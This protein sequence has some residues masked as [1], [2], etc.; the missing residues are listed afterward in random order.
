MIC[1]ITISTFWRSRVLALR[2]LRDRSSLARRRSSDSGS[3]TRSIPPVRRSTSLCVGEITGQ[4]SSAT[5]EKA[6]QTIVERHEVLRTRIVEKDGEPMQEVATSY[7]FKLTV[8]DL[9][10]FPEANRLDEA[11]AFAQR[12][13]RSPF[14]IDSL[15][16]IRATMLQLATDHRVLAGHSPSRRLRRRVDRRSRA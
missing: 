1:R 8:I 5:I 10:V 2:L 16:L 12:E 4:F 6:F 3:L 7:S 14:H 13:A 11:M 9:T 15:P